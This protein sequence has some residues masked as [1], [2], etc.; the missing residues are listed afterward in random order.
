LPEDLREAQLNAWSYSM[1]WKDLPLGPG[2]DIE[3]ERTLQELIF[4]ETRPLG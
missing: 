1:Q 3:Y 2:D 4:R